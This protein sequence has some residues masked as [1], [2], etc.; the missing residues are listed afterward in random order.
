MVDS[1]LKCTQCLDGYYLNSN[2]ACS[3]CY[4]G[5]ATCTGGSMYDCKPYSCAHHAAVNAEIAHLIQYAQVAMMDTTN[6]AIIAYLA[7][8]LAA[9]AMYQMSVILVMMDTILMTIKNALNVQK[10]ARNAIH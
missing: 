4:D 8:L 1:S 6:Q 9:L 5:C 3:K 7:N 10:I 2:G